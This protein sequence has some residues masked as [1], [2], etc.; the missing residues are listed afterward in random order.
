MNARTRK[1]HALGQSLWLDNITR[2]LLDM[3]ELERLIAQLSVTGLTSNPTIFSHAIAG[4]PYYD[5][6]IRNL[7]RFGLSGAN[8]FF[9]LALEDITRAA[10]LLRPT[11]ERSVGLDGWVSLEVSPMLSADS[12]GTLLSARQLHHRAGRANLFVMVP[13]TARGLPAI[14][15]LIFEGFPVNVTLLFSREHYL[16]AAEAY[17]RGLERRLAAGLTLRVS[18]VASVFISPWDMATQPAAP[19]A[20]Q[21]RLGIAIAWRCYTACAELLATPRW[22]TLAA[23]GARPQRLLWT[24]TASEAPA[25]ADTLYVD[26]LVAPGTITTLP[27]ATLRAF[28]DHGRVDAG[29]HV[30]S[31]DAESVIAAFRH[32]GIDAGILATRLQFEGIEHFRMSWSALLV[33]LNA[34]S[35]MRAAGA[36]R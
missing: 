1:L 32:H 27:E 21:D 36:M 13:G 12:E 31:G 18:S 30:G 28:A 23:A 5:V 8:L 7:D 22:Q 17:L 24:S 16:A 6:S 19:P 11:Y 20:L 33:R 25:S 15:Q 14:E 34:K 2:E 10:D 9:A 3:G 29:L 26:G 4:S 35:T